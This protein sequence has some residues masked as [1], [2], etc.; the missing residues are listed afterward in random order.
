MR[1]GNDPGIGERLQGTEA[2]EDSLPSS[3]SLRVEGGGP[4]PG[5]ALSGFLFE[6]LGSNFSHFWGA[7][8]YV[9]CL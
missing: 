7:L 3:N 1:L 6:V 5:A 4:V 9:I 2:G 8:R